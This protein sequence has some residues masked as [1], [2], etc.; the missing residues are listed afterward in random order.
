MTFFPGRLEGL[1]PPVE[2]R[3]GHTW[4]IRKE[5]FHIREY[6]ARMWASLVAQ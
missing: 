2:N 5:Y 4:V 6:N 3:H 1:E